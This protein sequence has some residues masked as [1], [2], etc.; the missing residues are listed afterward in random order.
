MTLETGVYSKI[1]KAGKLAA[2]GLLLWGGLG[3]IQAQAASLPES[4]RLS[5]T[6][7]EREPGWIPD[8]TPGREDVIIKQRDGLSTHR[9]EIDADGHV[10]SNDNDFAGFSL[11]TWIL[12]SLILLAIVAMIVAHPRSRRQE[13]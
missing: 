12:L 13:F 3:A 1:A 2:V 4:Y 5:E 6:T 11:A 8:S 9:T 10:D 7:L